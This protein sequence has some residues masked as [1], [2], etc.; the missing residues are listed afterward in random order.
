MDQEPKN[1]YPLTSA[2]Q[3]MP[4]PACIYKRYSRDLDWRYMDMSFSAEPA[5]EFETIFYMKWTFTHKQ[6]PRQNFN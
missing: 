6:I 1:Q 3:R 5:R 2:A 4:S